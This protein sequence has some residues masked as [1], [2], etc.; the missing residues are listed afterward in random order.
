M[1][2]VTKAM[3]NVLMAA[4][5]TLAS[6]SASAAIIDI[7]IDGINSWD[8]EGDS[9][10]IVLLVDIGGGSEA[11]I[12]GLGWDLEITTVG[13][14]WLSEATIGF[15]ST[16]LPNEILVTAGV[17]DNNAGN[18]AYTS[19]GILDLTDAGLFDIVLADGFLRLEFFESFDDVADA[20]DATYQGTVSVS[21]TEAVVEPNPV[22]A[23]TTLALMGI[24]LL[25]LSLLRRR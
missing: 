3:K 15:G 9:D 13:F 8:S 6:M 10:N 22:S 12:D 11:T 21:V 1:I 25:G 16:A 19:G 2:R 4:A 5:M 24:T 23:P 18:S 7:N 14:S 17:F 20:F